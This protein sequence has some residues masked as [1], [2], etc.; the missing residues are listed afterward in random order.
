MMPVPGVEHQARVGT[1]LFC[2]V[3]HFI[4]AVD[5]LVW[6]QLADV[7]RS[8]KLDREVNMMLRESF[9][10]GTQ[11]IQVDL[12]Q[13]GFWRRT[14]RHDPRRHARASDRARKS[15]RSVELRH[16]PPKVVVLLAILHR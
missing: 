7:Q 14:G 13:F 15:R 8:Q 12:S 11:S 3:E 10:N 2:E 4:H 1:N 6:M 9:A 16:I 5:E